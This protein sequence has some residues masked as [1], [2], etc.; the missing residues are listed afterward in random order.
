MDINEIRELI[1][2]GLKN[3]TGSDI[4]SA[5]CAVELELGGEIVQHGW[6]D[7]CEELNDMAIKL[8]TEALCRIG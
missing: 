6:S 8:R 1:A 2:A 3:V 5:L 4:V 7:A